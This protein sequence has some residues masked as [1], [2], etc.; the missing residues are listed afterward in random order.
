MIDWHA[1]MSVKELKQEIHNKTQQR[2]CQNNNDIF[3]YYGEESKYVNDGMAVD[4]GI[5]Y[6]YTLADYRVP[7]YA[8]EFSMTSIDPP[9][10]E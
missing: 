10:P 8:V 1:A 4:D 7:D 9:A 6:Y 2:F 5:A 3:I